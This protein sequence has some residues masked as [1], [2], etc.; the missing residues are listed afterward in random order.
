MALTVATAM[1]SCNRKTVFDRYEPTPIEGWEK[2]DTLA[3]NVKPIA[4]GG[5]YK[6]EV[7]LRI[8]S[9]Y[10]FT[11]LCL[12][13]EQ[14]VFPDNVTRCDTLNCRLTGA[15]GKVKGRGVG[16]YQYSFHLTNVTLTK[17][18]SLHIRIRHHMRREILPGISD[19]GIRLVHEQ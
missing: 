13:V 3:F 16:S 18:D 17:D 15:D 5:I 12:I 2:D 19:V 10:P 14:T 7:G 11:G 1:V 6:E 4:K 8:N 9:T